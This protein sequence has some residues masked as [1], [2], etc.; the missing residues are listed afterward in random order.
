MRQHRQPAQVLPALQ[1]PEQ[2]Q[3]QE[4]QQPEQ[5]VREPEQRQAPVREQERL[6][7]FYRKQTKKRPTKQQAGANFSS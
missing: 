2:V 1:R 4:L 3:R 6:L 7:L 5:P